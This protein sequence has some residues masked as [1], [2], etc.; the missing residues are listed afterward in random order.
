MPPGWGMVRLGGRMISPPW[1][2]VSFGAMEAPVEPLSR[3][4]VARTFG[5][6]AV[7]PSG[8]FLRMQGPVRSDSAHETGRLVVIF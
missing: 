6:G 4:T 7:L 5:E 2:V 3:A 8:E 1:G